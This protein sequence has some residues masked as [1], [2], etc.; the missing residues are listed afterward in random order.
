MRRLSIVVLLIGLAGCGATASQ[1]GSGTAPGLRIADAAIAS[2]TP[3]VALQALEGMLA[4]NPRNTDALLRHA[5]ANMMLGN[6]SAAEASYRRALAV[7]GRLTEAQVGL[8]RILLASNAAQA[9][10]LFEQALARD[11]KNPAILNN[12]G[13]ARDLQGRHAQAQDAYLQALA[14]APDL[15]SARTNLGLSLSV[16]GKPEEGATMLGQLARDG[17]ADRRARDNLALA[18][19]LSGRTGEADKVLREEMSAADAS[20]ALAGYR[21]LADNPAP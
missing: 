1:S 12:L 5:R 15:T 14:L 2:G 6:S 16:S 21:A 17:N 10:K 18:L 11:A 7:D 4:T 13:V 8:G 20:R 3:A 9:E 19:A